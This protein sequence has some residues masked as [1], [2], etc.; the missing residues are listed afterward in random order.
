[1]T[2]PVEPNEQV[3]DKKDPAI[4]VLLSLGVPV[5]GA[6]TMGAAKSDGIALLDFTAIYF[7]PSTGHRFA[8]QAG[9]LVLV[10]V[11]RQA[12]RWSMASQ[13]W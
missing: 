11:Q 7:G 1:M 12:G 10:F 8:G 5:A 9:V 4:A 13:E 2:P 3:V 6:I